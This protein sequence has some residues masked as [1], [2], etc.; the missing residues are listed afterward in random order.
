MPVDFKCSNDPI[1]AV[2]GFRV[3]MQWNVP[4]LAAV[5]MRKQPDVDNHNHSSSDFEFLPVL[6]PEDFD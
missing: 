3:V 6:D 5:P 4:S 1:S 2:S